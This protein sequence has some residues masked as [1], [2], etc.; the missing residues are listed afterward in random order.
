[1]TDQA[2]GLRGTRRLAVRRIFLIIGVGPLI[3]ALLMLLLVLAV[4]SPEGLQDFMGPQ[5]H[6]F[7]VA[8]LGLYWIVSLGSS[9]ASCMVWVRGRFDQKRSFG[10]I[11]AAALIGGLMNLAGV[12]ICFWLLFR[13]SS[14]PSPAFLSAAAVCGAVA[15]VATAVPGRR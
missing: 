4:S 9:A 15:L 3:S 13:G 2:S 8:F 10:R 12:L 6:F 11:V 14:F 1:M 7:A 5:T